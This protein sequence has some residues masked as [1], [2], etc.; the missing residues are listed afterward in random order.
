[1]TTEITIDRS[2]GEVL[3]RK[4]LDEKEPDLRKLADYYLKSLLEKLERTINE[5]LQDNN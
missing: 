4:T 3:S 2:T 5:R 1:M